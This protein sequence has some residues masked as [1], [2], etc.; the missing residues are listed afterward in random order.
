MT[1]EQFELCVDRAIDIL[2]EEVAQLI[3]N[4]AVIIEDTPPPSD[5][6]DL[7]G[8]YVG[9]PLTERF[10]YGGI[11]HLPDQIFIFKQPT[12]AICDTVGDVVDEV[13]TTVVHEVAHFFG[14]EERRIHELGWG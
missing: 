4:V 6:P 10:G 11:G 12:L 7:L 2:P 3:D 8:L 14:I 1:D 5:P 13:V 9:T